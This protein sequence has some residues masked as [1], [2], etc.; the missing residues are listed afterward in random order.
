MEKEIKAAL[1]NV[2]KSQID[3]V[4]ELIEYKLEEQ[5][6]H[7]NRLWSLCVTIIFATAV[8]TFTIVSK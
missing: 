2:N 3:S 1:Y 6:C 4:R 8:I 5:R 7:I